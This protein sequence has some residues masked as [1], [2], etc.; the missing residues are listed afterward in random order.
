MSQ[1]VSSIELEIRV[2]Y[3]ECDPMGYLHH[4]KYFEYFEMGRTELLRAAGFR[5][6]DLEEK[7][8]L[9]VVAKT[10]CTFKRPARYDD[11]LKLEVRILR[12]TRARIDHEYRLLRDGVILCEA[13]T[14]LAC[15]DRTGRPIPI[16]DEIAPPTDVRTGAK[17]D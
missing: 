3:A 1:P 8:V 11:L 12:Q 6:R 4:S 2:R 9:F 15:V 16:P 13:T 14:T 17:R 10:A 7:G 5:Y